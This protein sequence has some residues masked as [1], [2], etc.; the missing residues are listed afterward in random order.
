[1]GVEQNNRFLTIAGRAA[2]I[3]ASRDAARGKR[4]REMR[5]TDAESDDERF[6]QAALGASDAQR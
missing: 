5:E 6:L 3:L 4:Q 2:A 1:M